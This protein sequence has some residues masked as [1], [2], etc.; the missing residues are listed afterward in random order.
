MELRIG[1]R[2]GDSSSIRI[3]RKVNGDW[4][5]VFGTVKDLQ[6]N[7]LLI[8]KYPETEDK[9]LLIIGANAEGCKSFDTR[10]ELKVYLKKYEIEMT[11]ERARET[12]DKLGKMQEEGGTDWTA[13]PR[14]GLDKMDKNPVRNA[15]SR[16][17]D[18][19]ICD[20]CGME[21][22]LMDASRM[23]PLPLLEW[24]LIKRIS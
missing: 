15:L 23:P 9:W 11:P 4:L 8:G 20:Q 10:D 24:V 22:A 3:V 16:Y 5:G 17:A 18:C 1:K 6:D 13:C 14:C 12:L 2:K 19:Y 21:E 7:E